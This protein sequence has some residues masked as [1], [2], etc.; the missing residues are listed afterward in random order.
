MD[1]E[2]LI[3]KTIQDIIGDEN[4]AMD[5]SLRD[6]GINS[7]QFIQIIVKIEAELQVELPD[8]F[9]TYNDDMTVNTLAYAIEKVM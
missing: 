8:E 3:V 6:I 9:L 7:I 1:I 5:Q 2:N 4:V